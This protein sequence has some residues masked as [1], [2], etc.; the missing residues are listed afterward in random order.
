M[1]TVLVAPV[2]AE[3]LASA[4]ACPQLRDEVAFGTRQRDL[5]VEPGTPVYIYAAP[6]SSGFK[7]L[8]KPGFVTWT[9]TLGALVPAVAGGAR[10]GMHPDPSVRPPFAELYDYKDAAVFWHV[11]NLRALDE[12]IAFDRFRD[13][14][15]AKLFGGFAPQWVS[16]GVLTNR[17]RKAVPVDHK[18]RLLRAA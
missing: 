2:A 7:S 5:D 1:T 11:R 6:D 15:G 8:L 12:P 3:I 17:C 16:R 9:G 14:D 10:H 4:L 18:A 13:F